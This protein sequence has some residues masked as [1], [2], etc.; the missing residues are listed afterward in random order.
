[1]INSEITANDNAG[2]MIGRYTGI[3][4][5]NYFS[6]CKVDNCDIT[7]TTEGEAAGGAFG[8]LDA[9]G[10]DI[11][12]FGITVEDNVVKTTAGRAGVYAGLIN[13]ND[14]NT[15]VN[16]D[17]VYVSTGNHVYGKDCAAV[18]AV[19]NVDL[20]NLD[21]DK[22]ITFKSNNSNNYAGVAGYAYASSFYNCDYHGD[23]YAPHTD[24]DVWANLGGIIG[25][26]DGCSLNLCWNYGYEICVSQSGDGFA[27][28]D[29]KT[30]N[31]GIIG[32]SANYVHI[33]G[34]NNS[35]R[36]LSGRHSGGIV[37]FANS[38]TSGS[39]IETST[40]QGRIVAYNYHPDDATY[41]NEPIYVGGIV[42]DVSGTMTVS[43]CTNSGNIAGRY[44]H[45]SYVK[46]SM[47]KTDSSGWANQ[48]SNGLTKESYDNYGLDCHVGGIAGYWSGS[49]TMRDCNVT[50]SEV[51]SYVGPDKNNLNP[52]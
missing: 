47:I 41:R 18:G 5:S 43:R 16:C 48:W 19:T 27:Y 22:S 2:G 10:T 36:V 8:Y 50:C 42:G 11:S 23:I 40:N 1:M 14:K 34:T 6:S 24:A 37:G 3:D 31:G 38:P 46:G 29:Y 28:T 4:A 44:V 33:A 20:L 13:A 45:T 26:A 12:S 25:Y 39:T 9:G 32:Q 52:G 17:L 49:G 7:T 51:H 15:S 35:S 30:R 21:V